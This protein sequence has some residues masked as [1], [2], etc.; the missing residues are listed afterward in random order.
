MTFTFA[1]E[2]VKTLERE[3]IT[4]MAGVPTLWSLMTQPNS[5]LDENTFATFT[6]HYEYWRADAA[7]R[8]RES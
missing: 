5:T 8:A 1:R 2:I 6:L 3:Q 4:G 7:N